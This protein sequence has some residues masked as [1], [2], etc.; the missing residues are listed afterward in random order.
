MDTDIPLEWQLVGYG[1]SST[2]PYE[3]TRQ[4]S[5]TQPG[6]LLPPNN[7][8]NEGWKSPHTAVAAN[9]GGPANS[10][11]KGTAKA[12][13]GQASSRFK[14]PYKSRG[15]RPVSNK[16]FH[17][18]PAKAAWR[19]GDKPTGEIQDESTGVKPL[20]TYDKANSTFPQRT[21]F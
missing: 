4:T 5:S 20:L 15:T 6:E 2:K 12:V 16:I 9:N 18:S 7:P 17:D 10:Y 13:R 1:R 21:E 3:P 14:Q 19:A 8:R 11:H